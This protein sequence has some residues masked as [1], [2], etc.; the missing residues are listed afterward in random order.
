MITRD[1]AKAIRQYLNE[2]GVQYDGL[3]K[4]GSYW[5]AKLKLD[6]IFE[7]KEPHGRSC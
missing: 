5:I 4:P 1:E 2:G 3:C 6:T 7:P